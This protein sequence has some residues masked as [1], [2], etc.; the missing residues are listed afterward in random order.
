MS[1][2]ELKACRVCEDGWVYHYPR[3][4]GYKSTCPSCDKGRELQKEIR[5]NKWRRS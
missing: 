2:N 5:E 4:L 1:D 3:K